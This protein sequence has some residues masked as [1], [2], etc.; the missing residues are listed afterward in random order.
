[1]KQIIYLCNSCRNPLSHKHL[2][3]IAS[4]FLSPR[5]HIF[6]HTH[7]LTCKLSHTPTHTFSLLPH[8]LSH[9]LSPHTQT[10]TLSSPNIFSPT[11]SHRSSSAP[12]V[13]SLIEYALSSRQW[14][15]TGTGDKSYYLYKLA[16]IQFYINLIS[17]KMN[18][19]KVV[20]SS[21]VFVHFEY[22]FNP[23]TLCPAGLPL[24]LSPS[25]PARRR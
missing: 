17:Y 25:G 23:L 6:T 13:S 7:S 16:H 1:M 4:L 22:S 21:N 9:T 3:L 5:T 18:I 10:H 11:A 12:T 24:P 20:T 19:R 14:G 15:T 2:D 8:S